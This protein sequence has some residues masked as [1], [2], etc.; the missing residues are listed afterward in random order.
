VGGDRSTKHA[1]DG[2]VKHSPPFT[3]AGVVTQDGFS[4]D[5]LV[6]LS[7]GQLLVYDTT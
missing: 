3:P 5:I 4:H 2:T 6:A 1:L 7:V